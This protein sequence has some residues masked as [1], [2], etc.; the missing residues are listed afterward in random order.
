MVSGPLCKRASSATK[1]VRH[2]PV[3][4]ILCSASRLSAR[5]D[6]AITNQSRGAAMGSLLLIF[7]MRAQSGCLGS[8]PGLSPVARGGKQQAI[9]G[10]CACAA[11]HKKDRNRQC[12][13]VE[14]KTFSLLRPCPVHKE[15]E[16]TTDHCDGYEHVAK[17]SKGSN[18]AEQAE[19]EA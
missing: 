4:A 14:F 13:E 2:S 12:Q 6:F 5:K 17:D 19:Y 3:L 7:I 11:N 16:L 8:N 1:S 9:D 18:A 10:S 15:A